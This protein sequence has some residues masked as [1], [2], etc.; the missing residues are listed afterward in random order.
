MS[1]SRKRALPRFRVQIERRMMH[2]HLARW[3]VRMRPLLLVV[4]SALAVAIPARAP[5]EK[6]RIETPTVT[7]TLARPHRGMTTAA[8]QARFG[9][10]KERRAAVGQP[11]ISRWIYPQFVVYFEADRVIHSVVKRKR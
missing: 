2:R 4:L 9:A 10:P 6:I 3:E 5:A 7:S 8:V 1:R 11:P